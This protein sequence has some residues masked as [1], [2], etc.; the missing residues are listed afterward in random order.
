MRLSALIMDPR[1]DPTR[2]QFVSNLEPE[3]FRIGYTLY[4]RWIR[5]EHTEKEILLLVHMV[6]YNY[7]E[8]MV[9]QERGFFDGI[10]D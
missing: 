1:L 6:L 3:W 9:V 5:S 8:E 10:H 2:I 4:P 7:I